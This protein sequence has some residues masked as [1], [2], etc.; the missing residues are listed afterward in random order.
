MS[1][2]WFCDKEGIALGNTEVSEVTFLDNLDV[3]SRVVS[4]DYVSRYY[5]YKEIVEKFGLEGLQKYYNQVKDILIVSIKDEGLYAEFI[6]HTVTPKVKSSDFQPRK[7]DVYSSMSNANHTFVSID[8]RSAN[9]QVLKKH[10]K[11]PFADYTEWFEEMTRCEDIPVRVLDYLKNN[12]YLRQVVLGN[13]SPKRQV[14]YAELTMLYLMDKLVEKGILVYKDAVYATSD[15]LVFE[16]DTDFDVSTIEE[17][18]MKEPIDYKVEKYTLSFIGK[19]LNRKNIK[20][21]GA[22]KKDM[23]GQ[24]LSIKGVEKRQFLSVCKY[25]LGVPVTLQDTSWVENDETYMASEVPKYTITTERGVFE[26]QNN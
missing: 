5:Q 21:V 1:Y 8:M 15:E 18:C 13:C 26:C 23:V 2:K 11:L 25:L 19:Y 16:V 20:K 17:L 24:I 10:L 9:F 12:K 4:N 7:N 14:Y 22:I 3:I 6:S